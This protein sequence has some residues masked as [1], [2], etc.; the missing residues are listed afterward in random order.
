M[1]HIAGICLG[2]ALLAAGCNHAPYM[3]RDQATAA[4]P[5]RTP[6]VPELVRYLNTNAQNVQSVQASV[7]MDAQQDRQPVSLG[8][9]L[10]CQKPRNFRLKAKVMSQPAVDIGSN[11]D[12]FWYWINKNDPPYVFHCT[13]RDL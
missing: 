6:T 11:D 13:Y 2:I 12:E 3:R 5:P 1:R 10:A 9:F 7:D 4:P 8:G